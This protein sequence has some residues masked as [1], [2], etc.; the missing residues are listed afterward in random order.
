MQMPSGVFTGYSS[1]GWALV[2]PDDGN[3]I[4]CDVDAENPTKHG[5]PNWKEVRKNERVQ[6]PT[7]LICYDR[8]NSLV[9]TLIFSQRAQTRTHRIIKKPILLF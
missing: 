1:L 6:I 4:A 9:D 7:P 3:V 5:L 2:I 8:P